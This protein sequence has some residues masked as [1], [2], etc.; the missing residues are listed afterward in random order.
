MDRVLREAQ[1]QSTLLAELE[2]EMG[3]SKDY[4]SK[5]R[6]HVLISFILS[7]NV[8]VNIDGFI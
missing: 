5:V 7:W 1:E 6:Y 2:K 4:L 8:D 3:K